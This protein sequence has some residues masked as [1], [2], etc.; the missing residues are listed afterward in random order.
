MRECL[1]QSK[2]ATIIDGKHGFLNQQEAFVKVVILGCGRVGATLAT[3][4]DQAGHSV[5][6]I[7]ISS[8][9]FQR[10][11]SKFKGNKIVG[12]GAQEDILR[13]AGIE[14][15]DA[16]AAVTNGD[17][18]NILASQIAKEIFH[19]KKVVCRIYDPL[20]QRTFGELGLEAVCPTTVVADML[21]DSLSGI[22]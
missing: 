19:I 12:N 5:S 18:R 17:N 14:T 4:L 22:R 7:D 8:D 10:L 6:I 15:A 16:F 3:Q 20:R 2:P 1:H 11:S 21:L 9:A 13:R